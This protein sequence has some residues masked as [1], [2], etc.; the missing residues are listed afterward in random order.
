MSRL[1]LYFQDVEFLTLRQRQNKTDIFGVGI[2]S[3]TAVFSI[4]MSE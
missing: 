3:G 4:R 2:F 1:E